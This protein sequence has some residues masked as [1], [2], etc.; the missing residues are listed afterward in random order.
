MKIHYV[1]WLSKAK[2]AHTMSACGLNFN[3]TTEKDWITGKV[4]KVSCRNCIRIIE[5]K[6]G[7]SI[8]YTV[9][10]V[11]NIKGR[12]LPVQGKNHYEDHVVRGEPIEDNEKV[13]YGKQECFCGCNSF[14][15]HIGK[16][17]PNRI[18]I[19]CNNCKCQRRVITPG[20]GA[21]KYEIT[22]NFKV[23]ENER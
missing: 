2:G 13:A 18:R 4:E 19:H 17:L 7:F 11:S 21:T 8:V 9:D 10:E 23:V 15:I 20:I 5:K 6:L 12:V 16:D 1:E 14:S 22:P 3:R